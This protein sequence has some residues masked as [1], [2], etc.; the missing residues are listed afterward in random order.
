MERIGEDILTYIFK[1]I[2]NRDD[3]KS[4]SQVSK[5]FLN[6]ACFPAYTLHINFPNA[7]YVILPACPNIREFVCSKPLSNDHMEFLVKW[8]PKLTC[9][10][11][12]SGQDLDHQA[13]Y[14]PPAE[15]DFDD[16]GL[17][18]VARGCK[19]LFDVDLSGRLHVGDVGVCRLV[20]SN[21][22][23]CG[24]VLERCVGVTDKSLGAIAEAGCLDSLNL[25]G[26]YKITDL[27][28]KYLASGK[29]KKTLKLI[30]L[31]GCDRISDDGVFHLKQMAELGD[32][33]LSKC[34]VNVTDSGILSV[35]EISNIK[36]LDLSWLINV[37]DTSLFTIASTCLK[38]KTINF[39][40]CVLITGEGL[41]A[42]AHHPTLEALDIFSCCNIS[43][44]DVVLIGLTCMRLNRL[45]LSSRMTSPAANTNFWCFRFWADYILIRWND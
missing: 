14:E 16:S 20:R 35:S 41:R 19:L 33:D 44:E 7:L 40:G 36:K 2:P 25:R 17:C 22:L 23:L 15:F 8:C 21:E 5:Q 43:W 13:D 45:G 1:K 27:G 32:L 31:A 24:L 18:T 11:L 6:V 9:L 4:F 37:T 42:F 26:C 38:L 30:A 29:L 12:G 39:S 3:Q 34:G 10:Y 28:L